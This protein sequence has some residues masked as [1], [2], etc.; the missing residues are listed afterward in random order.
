MAS[1]FETQVAS[2]IYT[3]MKGLF[4][5]ATLTRDGANT[6]GQ[7]YSPNLA[8]P[9]VYSCKAIPVTTS[10]GTR[11]GVGDSEIMVLIL[12][13]SLSVTPEPYDRIAVPVRGIDGVIPDRKK[14]VAS[15]PAKATWKCAVV[16]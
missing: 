4:F 1:P 6:T 10:K 16:I 5:D 13:N 2:L 14:A 15:D 11:D 8:E 12:A 7:A 9:T 3:G